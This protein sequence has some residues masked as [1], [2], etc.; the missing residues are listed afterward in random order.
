MQRVVLSLRAEQFFRHGSAKTIV[1]LVIFF[2][3][4]AAIV[5][6]L[7]LARF[8]LP[9]ETLQKFSLLHAL[10]LGV[11]IAG[12]V[13]GYDFFNISKGPIPITI[14]RLL[15]GALLALAGWS[16]L[17]NRENLRLPNAMDLSLLGVIAILF[18]STFTHDYK[19]S[20][21]L[22]LSRLLFFYLL[23]LSLYWVV[24]TAKLN[25][26]DLSLITASIGVL[27]LYLALTGIAEVKQF[28]SIVF[29]RYI[30]DSTATE[31]FGRGRGPFLNPVS[32]GI[33]QV[34]GFCCI[35][36]WWPRSSQRVRVLI[37]CA[38]AVVAIGIYAT[39]TRSVWMTL[40]LV[41]GLGM[42]I[43]TSQQ[44]KGSLIIAGTLAGVLLFPILAEKVVSFKR[45][46]NVTESQM[47]ESAQLRPLFVAVAARMFQDRPL[48]GCGFGQY[49]QEKYPY[50]QDAYTGQPLSKT[51]TYLQHNVFLAY[52]AELGLVGLMLLLVMLGVMARSAWML[53]L[54]QTKTLE[55]RQIGL[56]LAAVLVGYSVN[57]M[58]HDTS[59]MPMVN[60]LLFFVAGIVNNIQTTPACSLVTVQGAATTT[61]MHRSPQRGYQAA[62]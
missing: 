42:W 3:I 61:P 6:T 22:P 54:D 32:N 1:P 26:L 40:I 62:S 41:G 49:A 13:I 47:S 36:F 15:L 37:V 19:F 51:K 21:N 50:L 2:L 12:S 9:L 43:T 38:T 27:A 28:H 14:D 17:T 33:F 39:L 20:G 31:F 4:I 8:K 29:P 57:G 24:R 58:F 45:D 60:T 53:W 25:R 44:Q 35:W 5:W 7:V 18:F 52:L 46:K 34:V 48:L 30:V 23:P 59:I 11:L 55:Q 10:G 16:W 56:L